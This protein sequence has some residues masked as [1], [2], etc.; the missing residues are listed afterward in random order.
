MRLGPT[1]LPTLRIAAAIT[2]LSLIP[3]Q[4]YEFLRHF[5]ARI[6]G[7]APKEQLR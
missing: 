5:G 3:A 7:L 6:S 4:D 2:C 1:T